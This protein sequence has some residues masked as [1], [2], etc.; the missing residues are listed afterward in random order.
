ME[1]KFL[2]SAKNA[3][4]WS[5]AARASCNNHI[6]AN[7]LNVFH[8]QE[9]ELEALGI[10]LLWSKFVG[11]SLGLIWA[12]PS[13][14]VQ[15]RCT[16][17]RWIRDGGSY[18]TRGRCTSLKFPVNTVFGCQELRGK[19]SIFRERLQHFLWKTRESKAQYSLEN[20]MWTAW[21]FRLEKHHFSVTQ[22][23]KMFSLGN[24]WIQ[25]LQTF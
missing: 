20:R 17:A 25:Q 22:R 3:L 11:A 9:S 7:I 24:I 15:E 21:L 12:G 23:Q 8:T 6:L 5:Q 2:N 16:N 18:P 4:V 19:H 14:H 1:F 13:N 10:W